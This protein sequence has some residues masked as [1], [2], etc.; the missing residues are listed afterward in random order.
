MGSLLSSLRSE[1]NNL[2][3]GIRTKI[4]SHGKIPKNWTFLRCSDSKIELFLFLS[5]QL[6]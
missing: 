1:T 5:T 6:E 2:G 3:A 4:S